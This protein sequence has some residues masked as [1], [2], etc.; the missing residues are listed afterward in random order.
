MASALAGGGTTPYAGPDGRFWY[1]ADLPTA[2]S[3]E[4]SH[5]IVFAIF[6][7]T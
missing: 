1:F 6:S 2:F 4:G 5:L 7:R 3:V